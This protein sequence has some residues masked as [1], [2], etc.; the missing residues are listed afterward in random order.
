[1]LYCRVEDKLFVCIKTKT[2][3]FILKKKLNF[4]FTFEHA[5]FDLVFLNILLPLK[6]YSI[7]LERQAI[8]LKCFLTMP[9]WQSNDLSTMFC[10]QNFLVQCLL[11]IFFKPS[12]LYREYLTFFREF[13]TMECL[14]SLFN[15]KVASRVPPII[16]IAFKVACVVNVKFYFMA[17]F[18]II[19]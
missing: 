16:F 7:T 11:S 1:M 12:S 6:F 14:M 13:E 10:H 18:I 8:Y 2:H 9:L 3:S 15:S 17:H 5:W 4:A 19:W